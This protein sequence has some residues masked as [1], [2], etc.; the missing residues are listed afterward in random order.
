M[1]RTLYSDAH[2]LFRRSFRQFLARHVEPHQPRWAELGIVDR[3]AW[4]AAGAG[5][6]LCPWLEERYGPISMNL[7]P[8]SRSSAGSPAAPPARLSPPSP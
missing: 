7:A 2:E 3:D 8:R 1:K 5:G 6:F 4:R